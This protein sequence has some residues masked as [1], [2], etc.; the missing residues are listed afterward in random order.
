MTVQCGYDGSRS[1]NCV[2]TGGN[3]V[4]ANPST[5]NDSPDIGLAIIEGITFRGLSNTQIFIG[6][7]HGVVEIKDC[8]FLSSTAVP[9]FYLE[10]IR[11]SNRALRGVERK[12][13]LT[14]DT[15][16][17]KEKTNQYDRRLQNEQLPATLDV[18]FEGCLF[19]DNGLTTM[20]SG[21]NYTMIYTVWT[22]QKTTFRQC[23]FRNND[24]GSR[25]VFRITQ[26][27]LFNN[28]GALEMDT[29]CFFNNQVLFDGYVVTLGDPP[30]SSNN[31]GDPA[32]NNGATCEFMA[33]FP[34]GPNEP[35]VNKTCVNFEAMSCAI[36][37]PPT[38]CAAMGE[39]CSV[40]SDCCTGRCRLV[41]P[42]ERRCSPNGTLQFTSRKD[43]YKLGAGF[44]GAGGTPLPPE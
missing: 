7:F 8:A 10:A 9:N 4:L 13:L 36:P 28:G 32:T 30:V 33:Y 23:I 12:D 5:Y 11:P 22:H 44:G 21:L 24:F 3:G 15:E 37:L 14:I 1:N 38:T 29:N 6:E 39:A 40:S 19:E 26:T 16:R 27:L 41:Q 43:P 35:L 42:T 18:T 25:V 34:V 20:Q 2:I 31:Y 17:M